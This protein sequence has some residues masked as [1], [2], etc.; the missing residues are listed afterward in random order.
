MKEKKIFD[1]LIQVCGKY[2]EVAR[3][4]QLEKQAMGWKKWAAIAAC[5]VIGIIGVLL[6]QN[7]FPFDGSTGSGG[8]G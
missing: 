1:A 7:I 3:T 6:L 8:A 5:I 2:I 4:T